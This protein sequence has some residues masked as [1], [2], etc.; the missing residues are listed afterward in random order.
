MA[1]GPVDA[2]LPAAEP[3]AALGAHILD[4]TQAGPSV[5]R[6]SLLRLI[7]QVVSMLVTVVSSAIVI[8][9]LGV[10]NTG[11]YVTVTALVVIVASI[12]DFGLSAVGVREYSLRNRIE[13]HR[14]LRN[15]LGIRLAFITCGVLLAVVFAAGVDY[16]RAMVIGTAVAGA[17]MVLYV[18]QQGLAIPLQV[19]LRF[20]WVSFL[21]LLTQVGVAVGA[22][23]LAVAGA[24]LL[25]FFALQLPVM[26]PVIALTLIVGGRE[27]RVRPAASVQEWRQMMAPILTYSAAVVLSVLYFRIAQIMVSLISTGTQTGYFGVSFRIL[28]AFTIV[29]P[30]LVST[31][32]PVLSRAARDDAERFAYASLRLVE[33]MI[34]VGVGA[35]VV[36]FLGAGFL[37]H[38][39][40]GAGFG[41]S[42]EV[43]QILAFALIGTFVIAARGY[44]L[45]ALGRLRAMLISNAIAFTIVIGAGVPLIVTHGALGA[46]IAMTTAELA[47]GLS[48]ELALTRGRPELRARSG[49]LV[50]VVVAAALACVPASLLGL[51]SLATAVIGAGIYGG[52]VL[53]LGVVPTEL[54]DAFRPVRPPAAGGID[55]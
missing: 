38:L 22:V 31:A 47:L 40:A 18:V 7:G 37:V 55:L 33:T 36:I 26:V 20:G 45:L 41:P 15:L 42:V 50:R 48:Y 13:G 6:G 27:S 24:G 3:D 51:P 8:R 11:R 17:G 23:L 34:L 28:D 12:S 32:L 39:V 16:T 21:Q 46:A 30:I 52:T 9:H 14:Y 25:P 35:A 54:R 5:I 44:A 29:P 43:M 53:V 19:K 1:S 10:V 49:F 2:K 4:T